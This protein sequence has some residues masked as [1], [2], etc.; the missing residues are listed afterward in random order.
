[1][2]VERLYWQYTVPGREDPVS[3]EH[4]GITEGQAADF[5]IGQGALPSRACSCCGHAVPLNGVK[6]RL[7]RQFGG[8]VTHDEDGA[9]TWVPVTTVPEAWRTYPLSKQRGG[10]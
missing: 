10:N 9:E 6:V 8:Y 2:T 3:L 5:L 7:V 4:G 1:M